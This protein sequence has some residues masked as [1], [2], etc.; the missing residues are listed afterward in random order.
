MDACP[1]RMWWL[2]Q[3][4]LRPSLQALG[5]HYRCESP[6]SDTLLRQSV[7]D[8]FVSSE[9]QDPPVPTG[10]FLISGLH[11]GMVFWKFQL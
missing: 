6:S 4:M 5:C 10:R 8:P 2:R 1:V 3:R 9:C 7:M 11:K